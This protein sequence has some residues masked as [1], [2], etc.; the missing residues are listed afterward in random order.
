MH[1]SETT[2]F[3]LMEGSSLSV[4]RGIK[5]GERVSGVCQVPL[6][7]VEASSNVYDFIEPREAVAE[8]LTLYVPEQAVDSEGNVK[9][10]SVDFDRNVAHS[11]IV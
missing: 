8:E 2:P 10:I 5:T 11:E 1:I 6:K 9:V 4:P 7:L 3:I